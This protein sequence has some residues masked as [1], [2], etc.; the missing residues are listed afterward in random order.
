MSSAGSEHILCRSALSLW[1]NRHF[2]ETDIGAELYDGKVFRK[3][4]AH[5]MC[6]GIDRLEG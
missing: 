5:H 4:M 2:C 3:Q 6:F 1:V